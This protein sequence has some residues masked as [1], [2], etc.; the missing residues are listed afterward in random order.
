MDFHGGDEFSR[1]H[2]LEIFYLKNI[3]QKIVTFPLDEF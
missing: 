2:F 1:L 3:P